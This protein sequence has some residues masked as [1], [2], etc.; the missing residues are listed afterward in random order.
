MGAKVAMMLILAPNV[1][2][3]STISMRE[4]VSVARNYLSVCC[5][6]MPRH[7][8]NASIITTPI[9]ESAKFAL[10]LFQN[11]KLASPKINAVNV[12]MVFISMT[13]ENAQ[14]VL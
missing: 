11:A 12:R 8:T 9:L 5:V 10:T 2:L 4:N 13:M 6:L 14:A 3:T 7:A 1:C